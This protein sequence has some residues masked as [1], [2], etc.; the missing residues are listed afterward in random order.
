M[1][2]NNIDYDPDAE[3]DEFADE[4]FASDDGFKDDD[5][6]ASITF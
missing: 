1:S 6:F 4:G 5:G 2:Y 3:G